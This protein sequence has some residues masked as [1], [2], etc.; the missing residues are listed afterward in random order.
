M[1]RLLSSVA[2]INSKNLRSGF[3]EEMDF[4]RLAP[5][6]NSLS[7]APDLHRRHA[8]HRH[9]GA[10]DQGAPAPG[11]GRPRPARRR[12]PP[13]D[14]GA[15]RAQ[16]DSNRVQEVSEISRGLKAL[17]RE[18]NVPVIALS[19]LCRQPEMRESKEPRLSDLRESGAIEQ[20]ADLVMFLW[21]EKERGADDQDMDGEVINLQLAKH[22]NGPTGRCSCGSGSARRASSAT[23][24]AVRRGGLSDGVE[25]DGPRQAIAPDA[26]GADAVP[27]RFEGIRGV[28]ANRMLPD[29]AGVRTRA[30]VGRAAARSGDSRL[31][32][33]TGS[34]PSTRDFVR[35]REHERCTRTAYSRAATARRLHVLGGRAGVLR[36][37]GAPERSATMPVVSRGREAS[38]DRRWPARISRGDLR[39]AAVDRRWC[40][41]RRAATDPSTA[42]AASTRCGPPPLPPVRPRPDL[43][44][45]LRSDRAPAP[46]GPARFHR[47]AAGRYRWA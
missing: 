36:E 3:L 28:D 19:Q 5:A 43:V 1:L 34:T 6:M 25:P 40:R 20:D 42:R 31:G 33:V 39:R 35:W 4:A 44:E 18:L 30:E 13:A 2:N 37:Q 46:P 23:P 41:S 15:R 14:A 7:E 11:G 12:L 26:A 38:P 16:R 24:R 17:A 32:P 22:R 21:R 27:A 9:D 10:A 29:R 8:Q 45:R 47:L